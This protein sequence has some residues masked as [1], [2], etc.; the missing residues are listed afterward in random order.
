MGSRRW[1]H[2]FCLRPFLFSLVLCLFPFLCSSFCSY[3]LSLSLDN[4]RSYEIMLHH[5][6]VPESTT[7]KSGIKI[8]MVDLF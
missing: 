3:S 2:P 1:R 6:I 7:R 5:A 4:R 8:D